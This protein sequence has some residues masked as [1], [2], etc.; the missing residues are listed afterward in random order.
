M[1]EAEY[2]AQ[3]EEFMRQR[4][5]TRCPTACAVPTHGA[6]AES[7]RAQLRNYNEVRET[8]RMEKLRAYQQ[9]AAA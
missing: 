1:T 2:A 6:V 3:I 4:G 7:D 8:R 9:P 5:V